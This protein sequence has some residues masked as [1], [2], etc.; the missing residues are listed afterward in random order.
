[1]KVSLK[2]ESLLKKRAIVHLSDSTKSVDFTKLSYLELLLGMPHMLKKLRSDISVKNLIITRE[3]VNNEELYKLLKYSASIEHCVIPKDKLDSGEAKKIKKLESDKRRDSLLMLKI[4]Q[5][6]M[7]YVA[8]KIAHVLF[9]LIYPQ[10]YDRKL[11][12]ENDEIWRLLSLQHSLNMATS[13]S[14]GNSILHYLAA[15]NHPAIPFLYLR[16]RKYFHELKNA[17]SQTPLDLGRGCN[18]KQLLKL[19][20]LRTYEIN[21]DDCWNNWTKS[22]FSNKYNL[23]LCSSIRTKEQL[24]IV[25]QVLIQ[26]PDISELA[27]SYNNLNESH[28]QCLVQLLKTVTTIEHVDLSFNLF[29]NN[30]LNQINMII[31]ECPWIKSINFGYNN[32]SA[33]LINYRNISSKIKLDGV[34]FK[35]FGYV[36]KNQRDTLHINKSKWAITLIC[37]AGMSFH[38]EIIVEG[39]NNGKYFCQ[40]AHFAAN[41]KIAAFATRGTVKGFKSIDPSKVEFRR[42]RTQITD[43]AKVIRMMDNINEES[44]KIK[45]FFIGGKDSWL[46]FFNNAHN[47]FTWAR[48]KLEIADIVLERKF[49]DKIIAKT[50]SYTTA[51]QYRSDFTK[52][53]AF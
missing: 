42:C 8:L 15:R 30:A 7:K 28:L 1:M 49:F 41:S 39:I 11:A 9:S 26:L 46:Q 33:D 21:W 19:S 3:M 43:K 47:C 23:Q 4:L 40:M 14:K 45:D 18:N 13:D 52:H 12:K 44:G 17:D 32:I 29:T 16:Y 25:R 48:D 35:F 22:K 51:K 24:E 37:Y 20:S 27:L 38:A 50:D 5:S 10:W 34:H 53:N 31:N 6:D 2:G 36:G